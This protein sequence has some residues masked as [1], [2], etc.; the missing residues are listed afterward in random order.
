MFLIAN[1]ILSSRAPLEFFD[2]GRENGDSVP[3]H[4]IYFI[5]PGSPL[6]TLSGFFF[7]MQLGSSVY[8][9]T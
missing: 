8:N 6:S 2:A 3:K 5:S 9:I 7:S 1:K 4:F